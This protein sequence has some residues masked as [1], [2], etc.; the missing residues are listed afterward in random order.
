MKYFT[1]CTCTE[2][3]SRLSSRA[4]TQKVP[5]APKDEFRAQAA[6]RQA[7]PVD[8][9]G[10]MGP[11]GGACRWHWRLPLLEAAQPHGGSEGGARL[12]AGAN[13]PRSKRAVN[14]AG[15]RWD[16]ARQPKTWPIAFGE[17]MDR[18]TEQ[19]YSGSPR[20]CRA[21]GCTVA[22]RSTASLDRVG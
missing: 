8:P 10:R 11:G 21:G 14:P 3:S 5:Q 1:G 9:V 6:N 20:I 18:A 13:S 15:D 2:W 4:P 12:S 16:H 19:P 17:R 22:R 7:T